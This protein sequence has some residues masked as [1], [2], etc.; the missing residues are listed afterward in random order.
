MSLDN[1]FNRIKSNFIVDKNNKLKEVCNYISN[2][3][4]KN[5]DLG[6]ILYNIMNYLR[7]KTNKLKET[8]Y[9][10]YL[11]ELCFIFNYVYLLIDIIF[12]HTCFLN[13]DKIYNKPNIHVVY[14]DSLYE[15]SLMYL[16]NLL[17]N[18]LFDL[19]ELIDTKTDYMTIFNMIQN[20]INILDSNKNEILNEID[21]NELLLKHIQ[22]K[23]DKIINNMLNYIYYLFDLKNQEMEINKFKIKILEKLNIDNNIDNNN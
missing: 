6:T 20:N 10:L 4:I 13:L 19:I 11:L 15:L 14:G 23:K 7:K 8:K 9:N 17:G 12:S 3:L 22:D 1:Y 16:S 18:K 21:N 5:Y 2:E